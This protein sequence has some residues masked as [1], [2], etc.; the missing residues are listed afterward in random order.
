MTAQEAR[1]IANNRL[2]VVTEANEIYTNIQNRIR[3]YSNLGL[4]RTL[5]Y[6]DS[7]SYDSVVKAVEILRDYDGFK[8]RL[9]YKSGRASIEVSWENA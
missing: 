1:V 9:E 8:C 2:A 3:E 4:Y 7:D 5:V 6:I